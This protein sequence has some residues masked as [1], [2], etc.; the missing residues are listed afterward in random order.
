MDNLGNIGTTEE[1]IELMDVATNFCRDK[2]PIDK[3]RA[4][5]E[6]ELGYDPQVW[7][8]IGELG[9]L[10]IAIPEKH[11][12]VGLSMAEVVPIAEQMGRNLMNTPFASTTIAAQALLAGGSEAQQAEWLPK[13]AAGSAATMA[14]AEESGDWDLSNIACSGK[15][16]GGNLVLSGKK[17][18]V[19]W[20]DSSELTIASIKVDGDLRFALIERSAVPDGALRR[21]SIIDET[22][23]SYELTLDGVTI[24]A[25]ALFDA[26]RMRETIE[27]VELAAGLI[28]AAEMCGGS[29]AVI[30]YTLEYLKTRKQF[31]KII[32]SYQALKHP[33]VDNYV[34]YEKA[35]T[36]LYSAAHSWGEQGRGEVAVRMAAAQAHSS[37]SR[38]ADRSIQFHG[39]FGFTHDCDAQLHRRKAIFDGALIGDAAYQRSK[40]AGLLFD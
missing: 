11:E 33:T 10:A 14:L 24:A 23:R 8:E 3:V 5:M 25:D 26:S 36:H 19:R 16:E 13:I 1:Q 15:Q 18:L 35:R 17:Q 4:L 37:Y 32:G 40:L 21:E 30:D 29:Q 7:K 27:K 12:G 39:G 31:D 6:D 28:H 38:A 2:S 34:E 9:W 20:A 22:A